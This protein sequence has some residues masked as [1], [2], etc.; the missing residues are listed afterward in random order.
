[1]SLVEEIIDRFNHFLSFVN[2]YWKLE[3]ISRCFC[4][5]STHSIYKYAL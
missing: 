5:I 2:D 1:M 3:L 4:E